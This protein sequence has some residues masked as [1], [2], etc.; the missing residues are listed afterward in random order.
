MPSQAQPHLIPYWRKLIWMSMHTTLLKP[1][2][3]S[4]QVILQRKIFLI[5]TSMTKN[6]MK[7]S[8]SAPRSQQKRLISSFMYL[9]KRLA[10]RLKFWCQHLLK[11]HLA[12]LAM[13]MTRAP[14]S[15]VSKLGLRLISGT[16]RLH[17]N[18]MVVIP[19]PASTTTMRSLTLSPTSCHP[20]TTTNI[21]SLHGITISICVTM[22]IWKWEMRVWWNQTLGIRHPRLDLRPSKKLTKLS[23]CSLPPALRGAMHIIQ[24]IKWSWLPRKPRLLQSIQVWLD[25]RWRCKKS[26]M[27]KR[28][29]CIK[30]LSWLKLSFKMPQM[31]K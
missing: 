16:E 30:M 7:M 21:N 17:C 26:C 13:A 2:L 9:Q 4:I 28:L 15:K 27:F 25:S 14:W 29:E 12:S 5:Q 31:V 24:P 11:D 22:R 6:T 10:T 18:S 1:T 19:A 20:T 8:R 23:S 3:N